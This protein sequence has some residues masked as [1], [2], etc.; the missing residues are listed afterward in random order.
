LHTSQSRKHR[1]IVEQ[2]NAAPFDFDSLFHAQYVQIARVI[3]RILGD[4]SR[5]EDL[6][7]E[8]FCKLL[9]THRA[10]TPEVNGWLYRTAVRKALD[11]LRRRARRQKYETLFSRLRI[12]STELPASVGDQQDRVRTTLAA[13]NKRC[14]EMLVLRAEGFS[15]QDIAETLHLNSASVGTLVSRAQENFRKEYINRYGKP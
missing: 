5:A 9:Q 13:L 3:N 7:V 11:E 15:Y 12:T 8:V 10:Q 1:S 14:A 2:I 4:P 6:A